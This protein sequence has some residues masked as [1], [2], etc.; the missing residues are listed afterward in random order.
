MRRSFR[1]RVSL[2]GWI[3][4]VCTLG[5]YAMPF[6]GMGSGTWCD[7]PLVA[8]DRERGAMPRWWHGIGNVVLAWDRNA[9]VLNF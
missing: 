6:Q 1:T 4:R 7:A 8:L 2:S 3:P 9:I 5:W